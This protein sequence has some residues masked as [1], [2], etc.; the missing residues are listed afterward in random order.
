MINVINDW[1][2]ECTWADEHTNKDIRQQILKD[3]Q[4]RWA[5]PE[6]TPNSHPWLFDPLTPPAGWRYDPYYETWVQQ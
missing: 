2:L 6:P 4:Q 5:K 3:Y 1:Q